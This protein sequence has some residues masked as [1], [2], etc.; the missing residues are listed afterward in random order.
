MKNLNLNLEKEFK[1]KKFLV[2]GASRGLGLKVCEILDSK[3]AKIAMISR[4]IKEMEKTLKKLQNPKKHIC[5]KVDFLKNDQI[6]IGFDK[7]LKFLKEID[8]ILHIAG[9][10]YGLSDPLIN[11]EDVN[12]LLSIN[13]LGAIEINRCFIVEYGFG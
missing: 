12:K 3:G 5:I 1:G 13:L 8:V 11:N 6:K 9:G 2:T 10:G 7:A 4:S